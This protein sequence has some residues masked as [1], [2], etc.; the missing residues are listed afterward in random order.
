MAVAES[1]RNSPSSFLNICPYGLRCDRT[2]DNHE[3]V[4]TY[5]IVEEEAKFVRDIFRLYIGHP[6]KYLKYVGPS[7]ALGSERIAQILNQN[8]V[9]RDAWIQEA[10]QG[11]G[12]SGWDKQK[13]L[14]ILQ[15]ETYAGRLKV[16]FSE[17]EKVAGFQDIRTEQVIA[18]PAI[19]DGATFNKAQQT[20][21]A[22]RHKLLDDYHVRTERNF[23]HGLLLCPVCDARM[24]GRVANHHRYYGCPNTSA[25]NPHPL[26]RADDYEGQVENFLIQLLS[27]ANFHKL[28]QE[29][30]RQSLAEDRLVSLKAEERSLQEKLEELKKKSFKLLSG[31]EDGLIDNDIYRERNQQI[32][33]QKQD[34]EFEL[35]HTQAEL[36]VLITPNQRLMGLEKVK[37]LLNRALTEDSESKSKILRLV[38]VEVLEFVRLIPHQPV[39]MTLKT[40][41]EKIEEYLQAGRILAKDVR[42][43]YGWRAK[44]MQAEF[45]KWP[46][47]SRVDFGCVPQLKGFGQT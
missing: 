22:R 7:K 15:N 28:T 9:S 14:R 6:P 37:G 41:R 36:A 20:H 42:E 1:L 12:T 11:I 17:S 34:C 13:V 39:K 4:Y 47:K 35:N 27:E 2:I 8:N 3:K 43:L 31:W 44:R 23:L 38:A 16:V 33:A 29:M 45:G 18:V 21:R 26:L 10:S 19:V 25:T 32:K 40:P 24:R 5:R 46:R 30:L